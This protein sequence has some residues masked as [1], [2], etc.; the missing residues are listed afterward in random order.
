MK[1]IERIL[2]LASGYC[3]VFKFEFLQEENSNEGKFLAIQNKN[4][5]S[6]SYSFVSF[7]L[8]V[9]FFESTVGKSF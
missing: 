3:P 8:Y 6:T 9:L 2:M 5:F 7:S 4:T 1:I